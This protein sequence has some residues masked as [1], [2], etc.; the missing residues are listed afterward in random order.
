MDFDYTVTTDKSF[1]EAVGA[2]EKETEAAGFAVL[3]THDVKKTMGEK[4]F[5]KE[6]DKIIRS[7]V[8]KSK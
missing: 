7:I 1:N 8:D 4:G 5:E 3:H 2:V 6:V